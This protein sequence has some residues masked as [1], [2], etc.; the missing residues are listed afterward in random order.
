MRFLAVF[1]LIAAPLVSQKLEGIWTGTLDAGVAKMRVQLHVERDAAGKLTGRF[2]SVDQGRMGIPLTTLRFDDRAV[3]FTIGGAIEYAGR[4]SEDGNRIDGAWKQGA[5]IALQF[6]RAD[7]PIAMKRPQEPPLPLPY[8]AEEVAFDNPKAPGVKLAGTLTMPAGPGPHRAVVLISGSGAQDRDESVMGHKPFLVLSDYLTRAGIAVLR[9]DDRGT[10]KS[11]GNFATSTTSDFA[12]DASAAVEF[13][14]GRA[15]ID[16]RRIGIAGH[17][18]GAIIGPMVANARGDLAFVVLIAG[19]AVPG[20]QVL[21]AQGQAIL[22]AGGAAPEALAQQLD[23][24]KKMFGIL[25][26]EKDLAAAEKRL[27]EALPAKEMEGQIRSLL[28]PWMREF[29]F[30]DPSPA[31]EKLRVPVLAVFGALDLQV[32]ASQNAPVMAA[33]LEKGS[34][35]D[36]AI[37]KL[38]ALNHIMQTAKTGGLEE[39]ARIEETMSPAAMKAIADFIL[40]VAK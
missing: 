24:Q 30:Y 28:S 37:L 39:Y 4:M 12:T 6:T 1:L 11:T 31:I 13:L 14:R 9:Y 20:E 15:G 25:R 33:A 27:K 5:E 22:K 3:R 17:S 36:W 35:P 38:P 18:E 10:G 34:N 40:R 8:P 16:P 2:D 26:E 19:P 32:L 21:Y 7:K 29:L 23:I